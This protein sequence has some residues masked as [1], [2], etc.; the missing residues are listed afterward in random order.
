MEYLSSNNI[1][2]VVGETNYA[3]LADNSIFRF[4][5]LEENQ[6]YTFKFKLKAETQ[7]DPNTYVNAKIKCYDAEKIYM[8]DKEFLNYILDDKE[9]IENYGVPIYYGEVGIERIVYE[10]NRA[11]DMLSYDMIDWLVD[12][13]C[14]FTWFTWHEP[15]YGIYTSSGLEKRNNPNTLLLEQMERALKSE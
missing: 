4:F 11:I 2:K 1:I 13:K 15:N 10:E 7:L 12:N 14:H 9:F 5:K 6:E 8:L 3:S